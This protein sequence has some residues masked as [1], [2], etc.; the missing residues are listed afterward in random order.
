MKDDDGNFDEEAARI[1]NTES[2]KLHIKSLRCPELEGEPM[3]KKL[4]DKLAKF[5]ITAEK[6]KLH[7]LTKK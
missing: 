2:Y 4:R 6:S 1:K 3:F 5:F 7:G